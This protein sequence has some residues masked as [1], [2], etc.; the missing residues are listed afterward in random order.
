MS[1]A[2]LVRLRPA[3]PW[4]IGPASGA[5]N[6]A[7]AVFHSDT[8]YSA[9]TLAMRD[10]GMLEEWLQATAEATAPAVRFSS[11][12]PF[13]RRTLFVVPPKSVW[14]P[15]PSTRLRYRGAKYVAMP[16]V[17]ALLRDEPIDETRWLIDGASECLMPS[18]RNE[19]PFRT[20]IRSSVAVDR[21]DPAATA[22]H[23]AACIEFAPGCGLWFLTMF[24]DDAARS[25]WSDPVRGA[26]K[27]LADTGFGGK[28]SSGWG[29]CDGVEFYGGDSSPILPGAPE[30]GGETGWWLLSLFTPADSDQIDWKRGHYGTVTRQGRIES[31]VHARELKKPGIMI[32]EGSVLAAR[33]EP[34]G[35]A[36]NIAP[37][38]APH[39]VYR[40][41]FAVSIPVRLKAAS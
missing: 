39:P 30:E 31:A 10:L 40:A 13:Q 29:A 6:R 11:C 20:N 9:V 36:R 12:F 8:L 41:G 32:E 19:S 16:F 35:S 33:A 4:R 23:S 15:P 28:R 24:A 37:E 25:R 3:G 1:A 2:L 5:R 34:L 18:D 14:P 38:G 7:D 21:L 22:P 27:L 17:E 26:L